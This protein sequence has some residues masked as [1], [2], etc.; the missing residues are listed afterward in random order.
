MT[1]KNFWEKSLRYSRFE[2][3]ILIMIIFFLK[4]GFLDQI[5]YWIGTLGLVVFALI[6]VIVFA[7]VFGMDKGWKELHQGADITVP[8]I[9]FYITKYVTPL[10]LVIVLGWWIWQDGLG[11]LLMRNID[12]ADRAYVIGARVML[13]AIAVT[14][15]V[16]IHVAWRK[17]RALDRLPPHEE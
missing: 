2:E 15:V 4:Y 13:L 5:D 10:L 1:I 3:C 17:H 16:G 9:F 11:H 12:A 7:C 8:R 6:E 14:I